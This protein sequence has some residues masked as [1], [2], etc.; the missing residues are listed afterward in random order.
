MKLTLPVIFPFEPYNKDIVEIMLGNLEKFNS[1][2]VRAV[3]PKPDPN[4]N[5]ALNMGFWEPWVHSS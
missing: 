2:A 1:T 5:P 4:A 3:W